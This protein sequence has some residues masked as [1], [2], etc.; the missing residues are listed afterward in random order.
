[1]VKQCGNSS[2]LIDKFKM[3]TNLKNLSEVVA[4]ANDLLYTKYENIDTI[5]GIIDKS[6]RKQGIEADAVSV[7]CVAIDKKI[8]ILIHDD[9]PEIVTIVT[10]NKA[11]DIYSKTDYEKSEIS[12]EFFVDIMEKNFIT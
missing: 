3:K 5:M 9:K 6:L 7:D 10:G 8:L 12:E 11:G 2:A 1:M 4:R